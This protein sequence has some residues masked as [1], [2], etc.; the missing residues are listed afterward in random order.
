[1]VTSKLFASF[2]SHIKE[3]S[4]LKVCR[5]DSVF[6]LEAERGRGRLVFL[7]ISCAVGKDES[8]EEIKMIMLSTY[9]SS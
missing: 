6:V 5:A 2:L 9:F 8:W 3:E 1:M 4:V 7:D